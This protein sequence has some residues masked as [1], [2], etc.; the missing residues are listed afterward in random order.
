[1]TEKSATPGLLAAIKGRQTVCL[2]GEEEYSWQSV[3]EVEDDGGWNRFWVRDKNFFRGQGAR[4]RIEP[5]V[6]PE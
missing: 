4:G 6:G 5:K 2:V 1:V 3:M